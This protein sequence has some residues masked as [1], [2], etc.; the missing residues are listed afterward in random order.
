MSDDARAGVRSRDAIGP[1]ARVQRR[2][3]RGDRKK[4]AFNK[5]HATLWLL[6]LSLG[7]GV[8]AVLRIVQTS[9]VRASASSQ[10][11]VQ[12]AQ[13]PSQGSSN[14]AASFPGQRV[15]VLPQRTFRAYGTT[16]MS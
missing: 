11:A 1:D 7:F 3:V 4:P 13:L 6:T 10:L 14:A 5:D 2:A 8:G 12:R 16:R 9:T 15:T